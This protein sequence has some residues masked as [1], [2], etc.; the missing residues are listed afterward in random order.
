MRCSNTQKAMTYTVN[1]ETL[2]GLKFGSW[3]RSLFGGRKFG[4]NSSRV[5][6]IFKY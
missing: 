2:V 3:Q 1:D 5:T 6:S 4:K